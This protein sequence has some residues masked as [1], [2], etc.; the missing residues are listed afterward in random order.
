ME[1]VFLVDLCQNK[2]L[3]T[4]GIYIIIVFCAWAITFSDWN[5]NGHDR[6]DQR[7]STEGTHF[8]PDVRAEG[9][10]GMRKN[11]VMAEKRFA[12]GETFNSYLVK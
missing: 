9:C 11:C 4:L 8:P 10:G 12:V 6:L 2:S 5:A 1:N 3:Y 7:L